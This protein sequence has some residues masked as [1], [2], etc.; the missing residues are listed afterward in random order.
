MFTVIGDCHSL[1]PAY[2][3][4]LKHHEYTLQLGDFGF[5][6]SVLD[7][8]DATKHRVMAGNHDNPD[9]L[10][11]QPHCLGRYGNSIL[12]GVPFFF[13]SGGYSIDWKERTSGLDFFPNE[14]LTI[15]EAV[16]CCQLYR[17]I[18]PDI[19]I[20][21]EG[22]YKVVD[23]MFPDRT[24]LQNWG[25]PDYWHSQ[26]SELLQTLFDIHKPKLWVFGHHHKKITRQVGRTTFQC[27]YE[28][29]T[30]EVKL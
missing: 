28:L 24:V 22:P 14:E 30:Y 16:E 3:R 19:V 5:E 15:K 23:K 21:H 6:Y 29:G 12:N 18:K 20:S 7:K 2:L 9:L 11:K 27:I 26:T 1:F 25:Y 8:V 17:E 13:V 4:I 10:L